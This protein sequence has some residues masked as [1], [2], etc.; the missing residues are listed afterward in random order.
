MRYHTAYFFC[1]SDHT[2]IQQLFKRVPQP[3]KQ[4]QYTY[5]RA[6]VGSCRLYQLCN[7][8]AQLFTRSH[9]IL[10]FS[11]AREACVCLQV[12]SRSDT[13][14]SPTLPHC[15]SALRTEFAW[16]ALRAIDPALFSFFYQLIYYVNA[17]ILRLGAVIFT[18]FLLV[19]DYNLYFLL[20][21]TI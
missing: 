11:L 19:F 13:P 8:V 4:V 2:A 14:A 21:S 7:F 17:L 15:L 6:T 12:M 5:S 16:A 3:C 9:S 18:L 10:A 20:F 1:D